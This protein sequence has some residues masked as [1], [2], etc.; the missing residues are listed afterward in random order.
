MKQWVGANNTTF[1]TNDKHLC[2]K[3]FK[4]TAEGKWISVCEHLEK[5]EKQYREWEGITEERTESIMIRDNGMSSRSS[6]SDSESD[7]YHG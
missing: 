4:E 7:D 6:N 2:E 3:R 5:V 1:R